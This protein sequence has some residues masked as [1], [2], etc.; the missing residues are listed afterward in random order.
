[1]ENITNLEDALNLI[2][3]LKVEN[4][5]LNTQYL[6][7]KS[8]FNETLDVVMITNGKEGIILEI[9]K[10]CINQLGYQPHELV[11]KHFSYILE[12]PEE[13]SRII[14]DTKF[15]GTVLAE[16][17]IKKKDGSVIFMDINLNTIDYGSNKVVMTTLRD[18]SE[19]VKSELKLRQYSEAL[20]DLNSSKDKFFSIIAHDL[21]SP[22]SGLL[23]LSQI[24]CEELDEIG[25]TELKKYADE[26]NNAAKFI[27][28]LLQNLLEWSR[29]NTGKFDYAPVTVNLNNKISSIIQLLN[30]NAVNKKIDLHFSCP[31]ELKVIAD[32]NMLNSI[33][34]NLIS[35]ALKF[36]H[37]HGLVEVNASLVNDKAVICVKD[38]GIGIPEENLKKIFRVDKN[39]STLGTAKEKGTGLGL[40]LCKELV[41]KN[42]GSITAVSVLGEG[43]TFTVTLPAAF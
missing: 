20:S 31:E 17:R 22:F 37:E 32:N 27:F 10:S 23:G 3:A 2:R 24:L 19:R 38:S 35:N 26:I 36:T 40:V 13:E 33:L 1:M 29:L 11:G 9:N 21:K 14:E 41:E 28:K 39:I 18:V 25:N 6:N 8:I 16:K 7:Y 34:Q 43:T 15:Y 12:D 5:S 30:L 4:A 42:N